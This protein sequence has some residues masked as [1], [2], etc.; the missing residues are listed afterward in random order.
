MRH[1]MEEEQESSVRSNYNSTSITNDFETD[2]EE[3]HNN[4][5]CESDRFPT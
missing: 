2:D 3:L 4:L 1:V 5:G